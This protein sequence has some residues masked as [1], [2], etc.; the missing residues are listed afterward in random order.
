MTKQTTALLAAG[1]RTIS[2]WND[3]AWRISLTSQ[4]VEGGSAAYWLA[5]PT[6]PQEHV[7]SPA[8]VVLEVP[9][10]DGILDATL[11]ML[12]LN[13]GGSDVEDYLL[14]THNI[15]LDAGRRILAPYWDLSE[16][17]R[18]FLSGLLSPKIRLGFT[19][20]DEHNL[21]DAML[22]EELRS[23]GFDVDVYALVNAPAAA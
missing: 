5:T 2:P 10:L 17:G 23:L 9:E 3:R 11:M 18:L 16:N 20:L 8:E 4:L 14:E 15:S 22:I 6:Q 13:L 12:A 21:V 7:V 1:P 19:I